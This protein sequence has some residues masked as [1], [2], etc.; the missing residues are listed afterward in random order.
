[1]ARKSSHPPPSADAAGGC[2]MRPPG[3]LTTDGGALVAAPPSRV[4]GAVTSTQAPTFRWPVMVLGV[5]PSWTSLPNTSGGKNES[6]S[7]PLWGVRPMPSVSVVRGH[8][9]GPSVR[10]VRHAPLPRSGRS[11]SLEDDPSLEQGRGSTLMS[12][13]PHWLVPTKLTTARRVA[14]LRRSVREVRAYF[15]ICDL[16]GAHD[17]GGSSISVG[18]FCAAFEADYGVRLSRHQARALLTNLV[19]AGLVERAVE[20]RASRLWITDPRV[21]SENDP[22]L[23]SENAP[24]GPGSPPR[25]VKK[26][27]HVGSENDPTMGSENAPTLYY[28]REER[29]SSGEKNQRRGGKN[30]SPLP[31]PSPAPPTSSQCAGLGAISPSELPPAAARFLQKHRKGGQHVA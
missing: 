21:G 18:G 29:I 26:C 24:T 14:L 31:G 6:T 11:P 19:D 27:P 2:A 10:A 3:P 22:N 4:C 16:P 7:R 17:A 20:G 8:A 23:G 15:L 30:P 5:S 9:R 13:R 28:R 25:G 12:R 1:M